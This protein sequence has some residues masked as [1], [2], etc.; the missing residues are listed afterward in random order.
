MRTRGQEEISDHWIVVVYIMYDTAVSK[1]SN[2][3][4]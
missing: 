2:K 3:S 4:L 1:N